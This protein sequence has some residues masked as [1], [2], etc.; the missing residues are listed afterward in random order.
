M[1][2][3]YNQKQLDP[4]VEII[5]GSYEIRDDVLFV[6]N[7]IMILCYELLILNNKIWTTF[8]RKSVSKIVYRNECII[9]YSLWLTDP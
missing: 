3:M 8:F 4:P 1:I 6:F 9:F 2:Y 7:T 5:V